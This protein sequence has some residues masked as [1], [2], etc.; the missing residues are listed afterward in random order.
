MINV[1]LGTSEFLAWFKLE[2]DKE[3]VIRLTTFADDGIYWG[4]VV[5]A[6]QHSAV[7]KIPTN[8]YCDRG[9]NESSNTG[10]TAPVEQSLKILEEKLREKNERLKAERELFEMK[11]YFI[12]I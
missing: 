7:Q 8:S 9:K 2:V 3:Y 6:T 10:D 11:K 4:N 12:S 5:Q 1:L